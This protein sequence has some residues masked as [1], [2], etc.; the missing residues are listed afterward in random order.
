MCILYCCICIMYSLYGMCTYCILLYSMYSHT[1]LYVCMSMTLQYDGT[2]GTALTHC[3]AVTV[4]IMARPTSY[5]VLI[6]F[7]LHKLLWERVPLPSPYPFIVHTIIQY[8]Y[9]NTVCMY[10]MILI[11]CFYSSIR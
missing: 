5:K 7:Y 9:S 8:K 1:V 2:F 10:D 6:F 3:V 4:L 11:C